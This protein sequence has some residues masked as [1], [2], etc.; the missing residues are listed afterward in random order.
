MDVLGS[1]KLNV[2]KGGMKSIFSESI[3]LILRAIPKIRKEK[4]D[5]LFVGFFGQLLILPISFFSNSRIVFDV[6]ISTYD[7]LI[8]DREIFSRHSL[9]A[10]VAY[11]LDKHSCQRADLIFIDTQAHANFFHD[12]F[13]ISLDK[14]HS[15]FVGCDE[16]IFF[17][18]DMD[19]DVNKILYYCSYSPLHGVETVV[20]AAGLIQ[21][22]I[23]IRL[24]L[25][26]EGSELP[27]V[28]KLVNEQ[29]IRNVDF[30]PSIPLEKLPLEIASASICLGG[31][32]G[33]SKKSRNVIP[34]KTY[35]MLAMKK[36]LVVGDNL[37][38]K[39]LLTHN[40][41]AYFCEMNNPSALAAA[42][43]TLYHNPQLRDTLS[44]QGYLT[45]MS[46]ASQK[47][48]K[49]RVVKIISDVFLEN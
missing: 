8:N 24:K 20:R 27:R 47:V 29:G 45:Y 37:A 21:N 11:F 49:N 28:K 9:M 23:P 4:Y 17:P 26:G 46:K 36:P 33:E 2:S 40:Y 22:S 7:T 39:E 41:D 31:H 12:L 32:F 25:I 30:S 15:V 38:N 10:K 42:I 19:V 3:K 18:R 1:E 48:L 13:G 43:E 14:M 5:F 6:F 34:G 44:D 16:D 35:Q